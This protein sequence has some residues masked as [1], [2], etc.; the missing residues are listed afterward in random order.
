MGL[1]R[2]WKIA[3][4]LVATAMTLAACGP[5]GGPPKAAPSGVGSTVGA[6]APDFTLTGL[7]GQTHTL[8]AYRGHVVMI[9]FW[10]TWCIPCRAEMPELEQAYRKRQAEGVVFLGLDWREGRDTVQPFIDDRQVSYP[11]LLDSD[12]RAY[13]AYQVAALPQT[14]VIDRQGRVAVVQIGLG[15]REKFDQELKTA[16][17]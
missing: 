4:A 13:T 9:N 6:M 1:R 8:S 10:A 11:I 14:F 15:T 12:G 7:D 16:G 17:A 5:L 2:N 3:V